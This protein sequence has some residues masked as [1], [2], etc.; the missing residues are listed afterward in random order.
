[1]DLTC[2]SDTHGLH[3]HVQFPEDRRGVLIIAG[4]LSNHGLKSELESFNEWL[5]KVKSD[6]GYKEIVIIGGNHDMWLQQ[7]NKK[8][9][10]KLFSNAIYLENDGCEIDGVKFWGSPMTPKFLHWAFMDERA[11][12]YKYWD[13]IPGDTDVVITHGPMH[14]YLDIVAPDYRHA[15]EEQ[16]VG[17]FSLTKKLMEIQ[18]KVH[19]C[20][21]IH[22]CYGVDSLVGKDPLKVTHTINASV[23]NEDYQP[24]NKPVII[25]I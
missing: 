19:V 2:I 15:R 23:C 11:E 5:G 6:L 1:M 14:G 12:M 4:D 17:C 8:V 13:L 22:G 25:T 20:G 18:P 24:I 3:L 9:K 21:H 16:H 7:M 10:R